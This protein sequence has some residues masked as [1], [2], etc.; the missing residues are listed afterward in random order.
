MTLEV[1]LKAQTIRL[2]MDLVRQ[3]AQAF[4]F[5]L[6]LMAMRSQCPQKFGAHPLVQ[7]LKVQ[8]DEWEKEHLDKLQQLYDAL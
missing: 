8:V 1:Q 3:D 5:A 6:N 2:E 7:K 4:R